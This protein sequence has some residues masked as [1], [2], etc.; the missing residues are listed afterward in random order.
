MVAEG[1][2]KGFINLKKGFIRL[3]AKGILV[4]TYNL[5]QEDPFKCKASH[6]YTASLK[7]AWAIR[8]DAVSTK[9]S[10]TQQNTK[11]KKE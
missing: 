5:R 2:K 3:K 4:H 8:R 7:P 1:L 11:T 6:N 10:K 9:Q